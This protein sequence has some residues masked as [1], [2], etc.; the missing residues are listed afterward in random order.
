M[1]SFSRVG[2]SFINS[3]S[4]LGNGAAGVGRNVVNTFSRAL[5]RIAAPLARENPDAIVYRD[6]LIGD[7]SSVNST[8]IMSP[9]ASFSDQNLPVN[10]YSTHENLLIDGIDPVVVHFF[11]LYDSILERI[12]EMPPHDKRDKVEIETRGLK[13]FIE[14]KHKELID[15]KTGEP[16]PNIK[17]KVKEV[18][19]HFCKARERL[20][21]L[22]LAL[23]FYGLDGYE[24]KD[25]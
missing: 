6:L 4:R 9:R 20:G 3:A 18:E 17:D 5:E 22:H 14:A 2:Q 7:G 1:V 16:F 12:K 8:P 21:Q 25:S 19:L 13:G 15:S 24:N 10:N 23:D 11:E